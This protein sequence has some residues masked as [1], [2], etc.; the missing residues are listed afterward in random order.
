MK[1]LCANIFVLSIFMST[2]VLVCARQA[3]PYQIDESCDQLFRGNTTYGALLEKDI[4]DMRSNL[5]DKIRLDLTDNLRTSPAFRAFFKSPESA[6][7][8]KNMFYL[9]HLGPRI[10]ID[11][12]APTAVTMVCLP[13][14]KLEDQ[15][16]QQ[17]CLDN[18]NTVVLY[19]E[20]SSNLWM[21]EQAFL[22]WIPSAPQHA[23][24]PVL[25]EDGK[26]KYPEEELEGPEGVLP[27][28][29]NRQTIIVHEL[30]HSYSVFD[31]PESDAAEVYETQACAELPAVKQLMNAQNY[32]LYYAAVLAGCTEL[33]IPP[34]NEIE[35]YDEHDELRKLLRAADNLSGL[36]GTFMY[37]ST[38]AA[39]AGGFLD[40]QGI[41]HVSGKLGDLVGYD[42]M[43]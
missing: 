43:A 21:C 42:P 14:N 16:A 1:S 2:G 34:E 27:L 24:C 38:A 25:G 12:N 31:P 4:E 8:V 36:R 11:D 30:A 23:S 9:I 40:A 15:P 7:Y 22:E 41:W 28:H 6:D 26:M 20:N 17:F 5:W 32:A 39:A 29:T 18:P 37:N 13:N 35:D 19:S 33:Y 3:G 10:A